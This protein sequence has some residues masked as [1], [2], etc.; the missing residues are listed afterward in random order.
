[1]RNEFR[2]SIQIET[3]MIIRK[4]KRIERLYI[5]LRETERFKKK[6]LLVKANL[7]TVYNVRDKEGLG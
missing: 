1:M 6:G 3:R 7:E 5:I 2:D 4:I